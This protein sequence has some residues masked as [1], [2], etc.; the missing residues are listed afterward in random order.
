MYIIFKILLFVYCSH[1]LRVSVANID[2]SDDREQLAINL[3]VDK[4]DMNLAVFHNFQD[5][6]NMAEKYIDSMAMIYTKR[7]LTENFTMRANDTIAIELELKD[8]SFKDEEIWFDF[9]G[10]INACVEKI[11]VYNA[12]FTDLYFD[13]KNLVI[14][15]GPGIEKGMYFDF[16]ER[17]NFLTL[18]CNR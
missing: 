18:D 5:T 10:K 13:Q 2:Y 3:R 7:Y 12:I 16:Q 11:D 8:Y 6:I 15:K 1:P 4:N 14:F 17:S 9:C